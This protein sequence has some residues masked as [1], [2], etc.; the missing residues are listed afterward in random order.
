METSRLESV[1]HAN[2]WSDLGSR[3]THSLMVV[4]IARI[5]DRKPDSELLITAQE[6]YLYFLVDEYQDTN[7]SQN[8]ILKLLTNY[9]D[10]PNV[11]VVGDDD[12]SIYRFQGANIDNIMDYS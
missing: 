10:I 9:W 3:K 2:A 8:E 5:I 6:R 11:F 7:G 12:Q 4:F 1:V